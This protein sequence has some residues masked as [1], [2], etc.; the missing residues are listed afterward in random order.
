[1]DFNCFPVMPMLCSI[2]NSF[3]RVIILVSMELIKLVI[4]I[5]PIT[6]SYTHLSQQILGADV[7]CIADFEDCLR[8]HSLLPQFCGGDGLWLSLI[9]I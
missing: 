2:A 6:V 1:M 9:H 8:P 5:K 4:P 7:K 3:F